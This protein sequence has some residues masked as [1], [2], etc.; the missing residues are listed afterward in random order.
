MKKHFAFAY[1]LLLLCLVSNDITAQQ[2]TALVHAKSI[3]I[4]NGIAHLGDGTVLEYSAIGI[5]DGKLQMVADSRLIR[6]AANAYD[7]TIDASGMHIYPGLI[8]TNCTLGELELDALKRGKE[9]AKKGEFN[10]NIRVANSNNTEV[11]IMPAARNNG[12]L[13]AQ[14]TPHG[15]VI[16]GTSSV[17][18]LDARNWTGALV[19]TDDGVH[20]NWPTAHCR[21]LKRGKVIMKKIK[22][23]DKDLSE[24]KSFFNDAA[25]YC[26]IQ[27][28]EK[29]DARFEGMREVLA[30]NQNLYIHA[31][32]AQSITDAIHFKQ[33]MKIKKM[34]IVGGYEAR[35]VA[36][37]LIE[38]NVAVMLGSPKDWPLAATDDVSQ[39]YKIPAMLHRAGVKF[40][41]QNDGSKKYMCLSDLPFFAGA[42]VANGLPYEEALK[43]LSLAPAE[44]LGIDDQCGSLTTGKDATLFISK[45]DALDR[46]TNAVT[47]A[48]MQGRMIHLGSSHDQSDGVRPS[49][50]CRK[51]K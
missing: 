16:S 10:P 28:H 27:N 43:A 12:I 2:N 32:D 35:L 42:A 34:I 31:D 18:Q 7:T 11:E 48:F 1:S 39:I 45:G 15:G 40:C 24:I 26:N 51:K 38:N 36:D 25:A 22:S 33:E 13:M 29:I 20:L 19:K 47:Y 5:K 41:L 4:M 14:I 3:L 46:N 17:V 6:L 30:G 8:A 44:M 37:L 49:K 9:V 23:Y 50:N 21:R